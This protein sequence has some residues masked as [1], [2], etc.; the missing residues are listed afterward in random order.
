M[1]EMMTAAEAERLAHSFLLE[2]L[3]I[4]TED[5]D[6]F[7]VLGSRYIKDAWYVV[8]IGVEG[9]PDKWV[10]QVYDTGTCDPNYTF[11]SPMAA[12]D[13]SDLEE[14]PESIAAVITAERQS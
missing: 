6:W 14:L 11:A 3:N 9:L 1:T 13:S 10:I 5:H 7:A 12:T 2:D 8:E 4:P